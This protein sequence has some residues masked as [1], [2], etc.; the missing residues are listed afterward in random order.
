MIAR[1]SVEEAGRAFLHRTFPVVD[2]RVRTGKVELEDAMCVARVAVEEL[3]PDATCAFMFG[4][5]A[6]GRFKSYSDLDIAVFRANGEEWALQCVERDG[7]LLEFHAYPCS[8]I[9]LMISFARFTGQTLALVIARDGIV[10]LDRDFSAETIRAKFADAFAA[11]PLPKPPAF[12]TELRFQLTVALLDLA[13]ASQPDELLAVGTVAYGYILRL[14]QGIDLG[15]QH[16]GKWAAR[17]ILRT[18]PQLLAD[19]RTAMAA[20]C[21]GDARPMIATGA[22]LLEEAGG[23]RWAGHSASFALSE[24]AKLLPMLKALRSRVI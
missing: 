3:Y 17:E 12:L 18:R 7:F 22:A 4:S 10:L 6:A 21:E 16:N 20:L 8:T 19:L 11:G 24:E 23:G 1:Q 9:D 5:S 13:A 2:D 15:W 14:T